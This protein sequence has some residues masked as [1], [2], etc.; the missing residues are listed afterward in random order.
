M[1][2]RSAH[3]S[4][5]LPTPSAISPISCVLVIY[6]LSP[7]THHP[8][9]ITYPCLYRY[10]SLSAVQLDIYH[11]TPIT[12]RLPPAP[13]PPFLPISSHLINLTC[14]LSFVVCHLP[15]VCR[16]FLFVISYLSSCRTAP[17]TI[18]STVTVTVTC[19]LPTSQL[20]VYLCKPLVY[21]PTHLSPL[22]SRLSTTYPSR[23]LS[24]SAPLPFPSSVLSGVS[25]LS[26]TFSSCYA[27]LRTLSI[28]YYILYYISPC[29]S[30]Y[31]FIFYQ[32]QYRHNRP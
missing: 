5:R 19:H 12:Y 22:T 31:C 23:I 21:T 9:P 1:I 30:L 7:I 3:V 18:H 26:T 17:H 16:H 25:A 11:L 28:I 14:H 2:R 15:S 8:S 13:M 4:Q 32:Y 6:H 27:F 10:T 20:F 29:I 24:H